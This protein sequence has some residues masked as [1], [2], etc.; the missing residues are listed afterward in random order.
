ML[1]NLLPI[2]LW[3][4]FSFSNAQM[5]EPNMDVISYKAPSSSFIPLKLQAY[6]SK[7]R[8]GEQDNYFIK[9]DGTY[10]KPQDDNYFEVDKNMNHNAM[11]RYAFV[12]LLKIRYQEDI[13]NTM[14]KELFT[15]RT[16]NMY[17][18]DL[19]SITAQNQAL[20]FA[21]ALLD[22]KEQQHFFCNQKEEDCTSKFKEDG[23]YGTPGNTNTWGGR[24]AS[25]FQKLRS[26]TNFVSNMLP[27]IIEWGNSLFVG[28]SITGYFVG[29]VSLPQ[30]DFKNQGYWLNTG[31]FHNNGFLLQWHNLQPSNTAERKLKHPNGSQLLYKLAPKEAEAFSEKYKELYLVFEV[32]ATLNGI[33]NFRANRLK[34]LFTLVSPN[35]SMYVDDSL[36]EKI[37][38][39]DINTATIQTR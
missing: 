33:E 4:C 5:V 14:D 20:V 26:F 28:N 8:F 24:G 17:E 19:K 29:K 16:N 36:T 38:E 9:L 10:I 30:Y 31:N 21:N 23:Y 25:E 3:L 39:L 15:E 11:S 27:T 13:F 34:T 2:F 35:V 12:Q 22:K 7:L 37:E 18:K 32:K 6:K 1:K